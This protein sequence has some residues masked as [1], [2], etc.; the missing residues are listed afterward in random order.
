MLYILYKEIENPTN[1]FGYHV[2]KS[3]HSRKRVNISPSIRHSE[4]FLSGFPPP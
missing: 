3:E 1:F 4:P 2:E